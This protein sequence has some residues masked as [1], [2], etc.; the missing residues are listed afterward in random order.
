MWDLV[1]NPEDRFSHNEAHF[2]H[3]ICVFV[4]LVFSHI[5]PGGRILVLIV[6]VPGHIAYLLPLDTALTPIILK[7]NIIFVVAI[8]TLTHISLASFLGD[9]GKQNSPRCDTAKRNIPSGAILF[10]L[11]EFHRKMK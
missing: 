8:S 10:G 1:G 5:V 9:I 3:M 7:S 2:L 4:M 11:Q 6:P